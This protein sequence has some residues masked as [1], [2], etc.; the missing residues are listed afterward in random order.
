MPSIYV[1]DLPSVSPVI[2]FGCPHSGTRA[3]VDILRA[4]GV[5][6]GPV[7]NPWLEHESFL[8]VHAILMGQAFGSDAW[9][10][11]RAIS[12]HSASN[13]VLNGEALSLVEAAKRDAGSKIWQ[14]KNPRA[15]LFLPTWEQVFP[16][17]LFVWIRRPAKD[18]A[19][20]L[21]RANT[22]EKI[23]DTAHALNLR[24]SYH[25]VIER[26]LPERTIVVEYHKLSEDLIKIVEHC[27]LDSLELIERGRQR[28]YYEPR[29]RVK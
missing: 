1:A 25:E 18:V 11:P 17:A 9:N 10:D 14:W 22:R 4:M 28:V 27:G 24:R 29:T 2:T 13:L 7:D 3:V 6:S 16:N 23:R 15:A 19:R 12:A 26:D 5:R 20:G 8:R 21:V